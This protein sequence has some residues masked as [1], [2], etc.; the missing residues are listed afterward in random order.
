MALFVFCKRKPSFNQNTGISSCLRDE[1]LT[2]FLSHFGSLGQGF[3]RPPFLTRRGP[4]ERGCENRETETETAGICYGI[5][6]DL[7]GKQ[8]CIRNILLLNSCYNTG[9][10]WCPSDCIAVF[11]LHSTTVMAS[12]SDLFDLVVHRLEN[13]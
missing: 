11:S 13:T 2:N 9:T 10:N 1:I 7:T 6:V 8:R 5:L 12:F 3:L 4:W